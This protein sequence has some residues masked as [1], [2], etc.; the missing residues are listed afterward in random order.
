MCNNLA[1]EF[2]LDF[3]QSLFERKRLLEKLTAFFV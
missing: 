2:E 1:G 3:K